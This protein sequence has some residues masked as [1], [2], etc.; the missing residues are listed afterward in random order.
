M[1]R[2][3]TYLLLPLP[4]PFLTQTEQEEEALEVQH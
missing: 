2:E 4:P 1:T 3:K